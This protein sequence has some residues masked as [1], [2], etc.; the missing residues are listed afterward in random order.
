MD[1]NPSVLKKVR[2]RMNNRQMQPLSLGEAHAGTVMNSATSERSGIATIVG[3]GIFALAVLLALYLL[4]HPG[5][6]VPNPTGD[7][8]KAVTGE[9]QTTSDLKGDTRTNEAPAPPNIRDTNSASR[10]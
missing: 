5:A 2:V 10:P 7:A 8:N 3:A 1:A 9:A 4:F 6:E